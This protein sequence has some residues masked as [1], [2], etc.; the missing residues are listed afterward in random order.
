MPQESETLRAGDNRLAKALVATFVVFS[1]F[2]YWRFYHNEA[3]AEPMLLIDKGSSYEKE[4]QRVDSL[5]GKGLYKSAYDLSNQIYARA[6]KEDNSAQVVK[7]LIHRFKFAGAY[8]ENSQDN[9]IYDLQKELATSKYPL[10]PVIHSMLGELYWQYYENYRWQFQERSQT[11]GFKNDSINTWD[12]QQLVSAAA[13][14]YQVS[15]LQKDSLQRTDPSIYEAVIIEG[16]AEKE[17]R[18]TLYDFLA[19]SAIDFFSGEEPS[20][21]RPADK[22]EIDDPRYFSSAKKFIKL[23]LATDDSLSFRFYALVNLQELVAF[24]LN[25]KSPD[26][27]VDADLKRLQFVYRNSVLP[28][29]DSL[30]EAGLKQLAANYPESEITADVFYQLAVLYNTQ[31]ESSKPGR[32]DKF[33]LHKKKA[34]EI[35]LATEKRFPDSR[36]AANCR[37]LRKSIVW[38]NISITTEQTSVP[39]L[40]SKAMVSWKNVNHLY[41]R[42]AKIDEELKDKQENKTE[43]QIIGAYLKLPVLESWEL[44]IPNDSDYQAHTAETKIPALAPGNYIILASGNKDFS[45]E[46]NGIAYCR[47]WS[48]AISYLSRKMDDGSQEFF[49]F[50]R[51][52]GIP[53]ENISSQVWTYKYDYSARQY[54]YKKGDKLFTDKDGR[55]QIPSPGDNRNFLIEF[56]GNGSHLFTKQLYQYRQYKEK[57]GKETKTFFFTDRAIYRP[58]QIVYFKGIMLETDGENNTLMKNRESVVTFYD[59]NSQKVKTLDLVT[60]EFGSFN[61]SFTAPSSGLTGQMR[62]T[63]GSG[64]AWFSI[65]EYK[66]PKFEV[67]AEPVKGAYRL[68]DS[69]HVKGTAKMFAGSVVD[70]AQVKYHVVRSARFPWWYY[71]WRGYYPTSNTTEI[72]SGE[73]IT[74]D[75]GGFVIP[76]KAIPDRSVAAESKPIFNYEVTID[77]TDITGETHSTTA[78][79][80]VGY[81]ALELN[82]DIP[83]YVEKSD[84]TSVLVN[85]SNLSGE[86]ENATIAYTIRKLKGPERVLRDRLWSMPDK[87]IHSKEEWTA[88]F[89]EDPYANEMDKTKWE[90]GEL[91]SEA[92]VNTAKQKTLKLKKSSWEQGAYMIEAKTKDKYGSEVKDV[93][94]FTLYDIK[95]KKPAATEPWSFQP[96]KT[97][98]QP[99]EK[100]VFLLGTAAKAVTLLY[101]IEHQGK[102]ISREWMKLNNEQKYIEIPVEEKHRGNFAVHF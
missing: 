82:I 32:D 18:P 78:S 48:S 79:V 24:H 88:W 97:S 54:Q 7:A 76:F 73:T 10:S 45:L 80:S 75:T 39:N 23:S 33:R 30:Y 98:S 95:D 41:F 22:F 56:T 89:P 12:V 49:V 46:D 13:K 31:G 37:A 36:G 87:F 40:P 26:A 2:L 92:N 21:T 8:Q 83:E 67:K 102:I 6:K 64:T 20:V 72:N 85:L 91:V 63:N 61:G 93:R 52:S 3:Q 96:I 19:H 55:I 47:H 70:G 90:K 14:E 51:Q 100:A 11:V 62:I 43:K 99:G 86:P 101:E 29:K 57:P 38:K 68:N 5:Q 44:N 50:D 34:H 71:S 28:E 35:C 42:I 69:I 9:A 4:W 74:N 65:E 25:D 66:R 84:T 1:A 16:T 77:V 27:L 59:V 60:N 15:L 58:G 53:L 81:V 94:Y 17:L